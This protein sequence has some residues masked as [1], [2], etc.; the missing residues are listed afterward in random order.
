M[1]Q[2][3]KEE[4]KAEP[5]KILFASP[6]GVATG[7]TN[8]IKLRGLSLAETKELRFANTNAALALTLKSKGKAEV[9]KDY[10]VKR[11]GDTEV[12][13]ELK[14]PATMTPG[15]HEIIAVTPAGETAA[16]PISII[17]ANA[18]VSEKEPNGGFRQ[19]QEI[20]SGQTVRGAIGEASD[21]DVFRIEA[22]KGETLTAEVFAAACGSMLDPILTLYD[23]AGHILAT[24]DD[25]A[26]SAD[27]ALKIVLPANGF[28][29][30]SI[31]DAHDRGGATHPYLLTVK[32]EALAPK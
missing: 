19:A 29:F 15:V 17:A 1:A 28:Y 13:F 3:K 23:S 11:V 32:T 8:T 21:V 30:L 25:T 20:K 7:S 16:Y 5:P 9:P 26:T 14:V 24:C 27:P 2:E 12:Q 18:L 4:K 22:R 6:L 10:D 31:I